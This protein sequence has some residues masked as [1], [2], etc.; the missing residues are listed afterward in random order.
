MSAFK[1]RKGNTTIQIIASRR[2]RV[3]LLLLLLLKVSGRDRYM[4]E[5]DK[6]S[7]DV[8]GEGQLDAGLDDVE[9]RVD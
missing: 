6:P 4:G 8:L 5:M 1:E 3:G 2:R 9:A 7:R